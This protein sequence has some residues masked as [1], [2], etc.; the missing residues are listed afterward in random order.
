M[1]INT[2]GLQASTSSLLGYGESLDP[3]FDNPLDSSAIASRSITDPPSISLQS[4][5]SGAETVIG[6]FSEGEWTLSTQALNPSSTVFNSGSDSVAISSDS[7]PLIGAVPS[8]TAAIAGTQFSIL[9]EGT[10]IISLG[11][12]LDGDPLDPSDDAFIYA[13]RGFRFTPTPILPVERDAQG[14]PILDSQ[15]KEVLVPN[16]VVIGPGPTQIFPSATNNNYSGLI[17]PTVFA[18][19]VID[20]PAYADTRDQEL[21]TRIAPGTTPIVFNPIQ[22]PVPNASAWN[23]NFPAGGTA[24]NPTVVEVASELNIPAGVT[25]ENTVITVNNG[26]VNFIGSGH[27]LNNVAIVTNNG[28]IDLASVQATDSAFLPSGIVFMDTGA[29]F[30]GQSL[31]ATGS[32]NGIH[33]DGATTTTN[34]TDFIKVI[35][36]GVI[37][38]NG[39]ADIRGE[40]LSGFDISFNTNFE[41]I[42]G[43][44]AKG[45]IRFNAGANVTAIAPDVDAPVITGDLVNDTAISGTN[46]DGIT[47]DPAITG[48]ITDDSDVT[49]FRAGFN[50]TPVA[51]YVDILSELQSDGSFTLSTARLA[52]INGGALADGTYV[53]NLEATDEF[54]NV[55]NSFAINFTLDTTLP[56]VTVDLSAATDSAPVGDQETTF[57]LVTLEGQTEAGSSVELIQTGQTATANG[58]GEFTFTNVALNLGS[59][60]FDIRAIDIAGNETTFNRTITRLVIDPDAPVI[61]GQLAND[62][63]IGGTNGDGITSD[64]A[65]TGTV[66][67]A[68]NITGF[69]AGLNDT[70]VANYVDILTELQAD[71]SFNLSS[72][73]LEQINGGPLADGVYVLHLQATDEF[74]NVSD[75]FDINFTL[76]T[77]AP[78]VP[79]IDLDPAFDTEPVGDEQTTLDLV[80]LT[81][82]SEPNSQIEIVQTGQTAVADFSGLF[83]IPNVALALGANQFDIKAI[84]VAGNE[85]TITESFTRL[86][87]TPLISFDAAS[88]SA[89]EEATATDVVIPIT[90]SDTPT[91]D[92]TVPITVDGTAIAG[93]TDDFTISDSSITFTAGATGV[94]L[95]Q[96]V[97]V[98][99]NPDDI[100]EP[101]ETVILGFGTL[102]AG[103][104]LGSIDASTVTI[105]AND[106]IQGDTLTVLPGAS[107]EVELSDILTTAVSFSLRDADGLPTGELEGDGTLIFNPT[108]DQIGTYQF[109]AVGV[110]QNGQEFTQVY[111]LNVV[112]DPITTTRIS[113]TILNTDEDALAGL[114]IELGGI[115]TITDS[116]G[117]FT[118]EVSGPLPSDTLRVLGQDFDDGSGDEYPFIAEKLELVLEHDPYIGFNNIIDRPLYL[119]VLDTANAVPIIPGSGTDV[120]TSNIP[121]ASVFVAADSIVDQEGNP[122]DGDLSI[123]EVPRE[124][125]PA[126][127]PE[128]LIPDVVVTIQPGEMEFTTPAPLTLPN[129]AGYDEGLEMTLWSINPI[130]GEFD[131]VG[132]GVVAPGDEGSGG[133]VITTTEGGIRN[134]SWHFWA[135]TL[136]GAGDPPLFAYAQDDEADCGGGDDC[137]K[138]SQPYTSEVR[139]YSGAVIERHELVTY[140]SLGETR[141]VSLV[142]DSGRAD[143]RPIVNFTFE[144]AT[145]GSSQFQRLVADLTIKQDDFEY[146]VPGSAAGDFGLSA[147]QHFW[148]FQSGSLTAGLQAD[149]S[150]LS[151]GR[152]EFEMDTGLIWFDPIANN[153]SGTT[154]TQTGN[155]I[156]I[157]S[158]NSPFGSGWGMAGLQELVINDDGS[159]LLIDGASGELLFEAPT[160]PGDPYISPAGDFSTLVQLTDGTFQRTMKDQTV[161]TFN[162]DNMLASMVDRNGNATTYVYN[163]LGFLEKMIDPVGLETTFTYNANNKVSSI[164]DSSN[165]ITTLG[166]D[167]DGNLATITD[168][169]NT[170]RT[171]SYDDRHHITSETDKRNNIEKTYY[172]FAG[173]ADYAITK[174]NERIEVEPFQSSV[175]ANPTQT[176]DALNAPTAKPTDEIKAVYTDANGQ[177]SLITLDRR[178]QIVSAS[179]QQGFM[180]SEQRDE[181]TNL[182]SE[183]VDARGNIT[184]YQYD[185]NG[186]ITGIVDTPGPRVSFGNA[187]SYGVGDFPNAI[188]L[189]DLNEDGISDLVT[190]STFNDQFIN[191]IFGDVSGGFTNR[192]DI[193]VS[194]NV[195]FNNELPIGDLNGDNHLDLIVGDTSE[196]DLYFGDGNGN[197]SSNPSSSVLFNNGTA[198][199]TSPVNVTDLDLDGDLDIVAEVA[200]V[201]DTLITNVAFAL[202]QGDGSFSAPTGVGT[203]GDVSKSALADLNN[204]GFSDLVSIANSFGGTSIF[205]SINDSNGSFNSPISIPTGGIDL[206]DGANIEVGDF[207]GDNNLDLATPSGSNS[208]AIL[209]G[210]GEGGFVNISSFNFGSQLSQLQVGDI[211]QDGISDIVAARSFES[212]VAVLLGQGNGTFDAAIDLPSDFYGES[213]VLLG[214][215]NGDNILDIAALNL[216][217][218]PDIDGLDN[219]NVSV[220]LT[221]G[222]NPLFGDPNVIAGQQTITYDPEF[223]QITSTTDELGRQT[224]LEIDPNNGNL[225]SETR[226]AGA[227]G[228]SDD[229]ITTYTYTPAGQIDTMTDQLGR[230]TDNDYDSFGNLTR[231]TYAKG[232]SDEASQEFKYDAAG[233]QTEVKDENGNI[234]RYD[235]DDL[236]RLIKITE[237]DPDG[238]GPLNSPITTYTYDE[239]GN[240]I[241]MTDPLGRTTVNGYDEMDRLISITEPDPDGDG[242]QASPITIIEYDSFGNR[243]EEIDPLGNITEYRYDNRNRLI[244][245]NYPNGE[246]EIIEYDSDDNVSSRTDANGNE[247]AY[248]YDNQGRMAFRTD[249]IT[250]TSFVYDAAGQLI[251]TESNGNK[252]KRDYD[253]LGRRTLT[254]DST[255]GITQTEYDLVG[256]IVLEV[257]PLGNSTQYIYDNRYREVEVIDALNGRT[258]TEYDK[259]GNILSITD[260]VNNTTEF[261]YDNLNRKVSEENALGGV[262]TFTYD[263]VGNLTNYI[264]RNGR[265]TSFTYDGL[266]RTISEEWLNSSEEPVSSINFTYDI[267][268]RITSAD[269]GNAIYSYTY[270]EK[271]R[272]ITISR[273]GVSGAPDVLLSYE[274]DDFGNPVSLTEQINGQTAGKISYSYGAENRLEQIIQSGEGISDKRV[275][276]IYDSEGKISSL[277]RYSDLTA[278]QPVINTN[279]SFDQVRQLDRISHNQS[280]SEVAFYDFSYDPGSRINQINSIDGV[281]GY[282]YDDNNRLLTADNTNTVSIDEAYSYD[283]N[284]NR[285]N[286]GYQTGVNNQLLSD[287][288]YNYEYDLEGNLILRTDIATN[289]TREYQWDHRNRLVGIQDK[290][291]T[292]DLIAK[293]DYTYD[294][295]NQRIK[296]EADLD[297]AG[298]AES[299]VIHFVHDRNNILLEFDS[300]ISSVQPSN[301]YLYGL[302]SDE[303]LAQENDS[304]EVSWVLRD[305]IGTVRD[306]VDNN[307][308]VLNH[309]SYDSFGNILNESNSNLNS[310]H[311]F[312]GREYDKETG[313][314][315]YRNRYYDSTTG[316]FLNEDPLG[317]GGG[318]TNLYAYVANDPLHF[319]DP[320]GTEK[321]VGEVLPGRIYSREIKYVNKWRKTTD[322]DSQSEIARKRNRF[323]GPLYIVEDNFAVDFQ[324]IKKAVNERSLKPK[325]EQILG[326]RTRTNG[327]ADDRGHILPFLVGGNGNFDYNRPNNFFWQNRKVNRGVYTTYGEK[328][329]EKMSFFADDDDCYPH[330]VMNLKASFFYDRKTSPLR[331]KGFTVKTTAKLTLPGPINLP[332]VGGV[333]FPEIRGINFNDL[334]QSFLNLPSGAYSS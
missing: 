288:E 268:N 139:L 50:G 248:L 6:I 178:G 184:A 33:F 256:N 195:F 5:G 325:P 46:S 173:R 185:S 68:N 212:T 126:A 121:G 58:I 232:T 197:F 100:P 228:G 96:N 3:I 250:T 12:D 319:N 318:D 239:H 67:D 22:N 137:S 135:P 317:F 51:N 208:I 165:R 171:F 260:P 221:N 211:D 222:I 106:A 302:D 301:R 56:T 179:D 27:T 115:Q 296:K 90:L 333:L 254:T 48:T 192:V 199:G 85:T 122:F 47:S 41:L 202:N 95:T 168:P 1:N 161:Y 183:R 145:R 62:T 119:P 142:Y 54:G 312:T 150:T 146:Q 104:E 172:D 107:V 55:S 163:G 294:H 298:S 224:L 263:D 204:D 94:D 42:G 293:F 290:T 177:Q 206:D 164:I 226:V 128:N 102:P 124:L 16:A 111:T 265:I 15:G 214:N 274:Y 280:G 176:T 110:D 140:Q 289:N 170:T 70:P 52:Q 156:S 148:D 83:S 120:T 257:D 334:T 326:N 17:P 7:D 230:V 235:Y 71:G 327:I 169:D 209:L 86:D 66:T 187:N 297:G 112:A 29:R 287:G 13:D 255:G 93:A 84:D 138:E 30:G 4:D 167:A 324:P 109:T 249:S 9:A 284:G 223:N 116:N 81:G 40:F 253:D 53:L 114:P 282:T 304:N 216:D 74:G 321:R 133:S 103:V 332:A 26:A 243:T 39:S 154:L 330:I 275:D 194:S 270:D 281:T 188:G 272:I 34:E 303:I 307:G 314:Y 295:Q 99:I 160:T 11:G 174:D 72:A 299:E 88:F 162:F 306:V 285:T 242:V 276:Y 220:I 182:V 316:R 158:I 65:I 123:T 186:N 24:S 246:F 75:S 190:T 315:Q 64:P 292:G 175:L 261:T 60:S 43:I 131:N 273:I 225:L 91:A 130:T 155:L 38:F 20:I 157:N 241:T 300:N 231:I 238:E 78:A 57:D 118:I 329:A 134:S 271:G 218:D 180:P 259:A 153:Y 236:N 8:P 213:K 45:N 198:I 286:S 210:D 322:S 151:S 23:N 313:L 132:V 310:R 79:T 32:P 244:R 127:L 217:D 149:L 262:R 308:L 80:T 10:L 196:L 267:A 92:V 82:Q 189:G 141:G 200:A 117:E 219:N 129:R 113:G 101:D 31:I 35:A 136:G 251:E 266:N 77:T 331:P 237:S 147:G 49:S 328:I 63:A 269:D 166:Y 205:V 14:N 191:L 240:E 203:N 247:V 311:L 152:Y 323:D 258:I 44:A 21:D 2:E 108:P 207:N 98:T 305:H 278:N 227:V 61:T 73:V 159:V 245:T 193:P 28:S 283:A 37:N 87:N 252:I 291:A 59:N 125:T 181:A 229:V 279:Y 143:P 201:T 320:N 144:D 18:E 309:L 36:Q 89:T 234:T 19:Q 69:V 233:N 264:D 277:E 76:D 105:A 97:T 215:L 25:I